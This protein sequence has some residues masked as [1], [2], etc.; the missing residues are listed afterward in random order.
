VT[1]QTV[2]K[3]RQRENQQDLSHCPHHLN[4]TLSQDEELLVVEIRKLLL[5]PLDD[6]LVV[7]RRFIN[8]KAS[9][10]GI[11]RCLQRYHVSNLKALEAEQRLERG[12]LPEEK[13]KKSFKD[14]LPGFIHIDIKYLPKMPDEEQR[15]YLFV[16]IDRA[17]RWVFLTI[18][19]DQT[20]ESSVDFLEQLVA[21]SP[22]RI[23]KIV[24]DNGTQFTDRFTCKQKEPS[25]QHEFDKACAKEGIVHRL[26]PPRHPQTNGMVERFNGRI[27]ELV[28][29]TRFTS[30]AELET[31]LLSYMAIYNY[32]IPQRSLQHQTP[33]QALQ[34]WFETKPEIFKKSVHNHPIP[35]I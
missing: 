11:G 28:K 7:T 26:I 16:G 5:L 3:W 30:G 2:R 31:T 13:A 17:T 33:I 29:Q 18:Y 4:T 12:E 27:S 22:V 34:K 15:R 32:H 10:A 21:H 23:E 1:R 24:T 8:A 14:Y 20:Q 6:L 25:G 19:D 9:R 35:D